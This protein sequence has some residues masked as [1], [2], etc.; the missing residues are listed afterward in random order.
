[1]WLHEEKPKADGLVD[2]KFYCFNGEPKFLYVGF[3]NIVNGEKHD[4][5]SFL[6]LDWKSTPFYRKDHE[7]FPFELNKPECFEQMVDI[8]KKLSKSISFVRIDLYCI[9]EKIYFSEATFCPGGG[10]GRFYPDEW[11]EKL[12]EWIDLARS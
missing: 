4:Q 11:E 9:D 8:A 5:L 10:Y 7:P 6:D 3:A 2:Y 12:G 1:M